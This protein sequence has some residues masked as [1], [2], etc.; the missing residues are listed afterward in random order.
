[1]IDLLQKGIALAIS[2]AGIL[3]T[4]YRMVFV[5]RKRRQQAYYQKLLKLFIKAYHENNHIN[6]VEFINE[7]VE[8]N[9]DDIPKYIFYLMDQNENII[10]KQVLIYDYFDLYHNDGTMM[11]YGMRI[12]PQGLIYILFIVI[13][14]TTIYSVFNLVMSCLPAII[15]LI[16]AGSITEIYLKE[17]IMRTAKSI[18]II[19]L[20]CIGLVIEYILYD[21][22][23]TFDKKKIKKIINKKVKGY[24]KHTTKYI[25]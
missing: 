20:D 18:F 17:V 22:I 3:T 2:I 12:L 8:R 7:K 14:L 19:V 9:D 11:I 4:I 25:F 5:K 1:M 24:Y 23:Y 13:L 10:L 16:Y 21:D 6:A 15:K